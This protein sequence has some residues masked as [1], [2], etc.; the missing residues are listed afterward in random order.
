[1]SIDYFL[2]TWKVTASSSVVRKGQRITIQR[3]PGGGE[4]ALEF[5]APSTPEPGAVKGFGDGGWEAVKDLRYVTKG[6]EAGAVT[7]TAQ[8]GQSNN[9]IFIRSSPYDGHKFINCEIYQLSSSVSRSAARGIFAKISRYR[10]AA[11]NEGEDFRA[12]LP[13]IAERLNLPGNIF[14]EAGEWEA[15]DD[16]G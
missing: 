8:V 9:M 3:K 5:A 7:G 13:R 10:R 11:E 15:E 1:M 6:V 4:N 16:G 12:A 2:R 14:E